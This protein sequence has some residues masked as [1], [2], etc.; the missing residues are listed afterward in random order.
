MAPV[1][2]DSWGEEEVHARALD[3]KRKWLRRAEQELLK[4][5]MKKNKADPN[6]VSLQPLHTGIHCVIAALRLCAACLMCED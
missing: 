5:T 4:K 3:I 2:R 6:K 1:D